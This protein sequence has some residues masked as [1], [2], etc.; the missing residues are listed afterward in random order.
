M[1][2][3]RQHHHILSILCCSIQLDF[4]LK[5]KFVEVFGECVIFAVRRDLRLHLPSIF[6]HFL[7]SRLELCEV[8]FATF[9]V[10]FPLPF[11]KS[12]VNS[13]WPSLAVCTQLSYC[14]LPLLT[15]FRFLKI[16]QTC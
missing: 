12:S 3:M 13:E 6:N 9:I 2:F 11:Q 7:C 10:P 14:Y 4:L 5:Y 8:F 15:L 1:F 16:T